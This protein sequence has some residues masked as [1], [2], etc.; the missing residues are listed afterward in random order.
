MLSESVKFHSLKLTMMFKLNLEKKS[1]R[2]SE[3]VQNEFQKSI[4]F[5]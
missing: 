2:L 1:R 4:Y 5:A 3:P